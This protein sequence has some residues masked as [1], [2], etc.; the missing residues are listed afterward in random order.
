MIITFILHFPRICSTVFLA[1]IC[2]VVMHC[3]FYP[4]NSFHLSSLSA[5]LCLLFTGAL[6]VSANSSGF[7]HQRKVIH[8]SDVHCTGWERGIMECA[9]FTHTLDDGIMLMRNVKLEVVAVQCVS[10]CPPIQSSNSTNSTPNS[11]APECS[12]PDTRGKELVPLNYSKCVLFCAC[13]LN[14][15][16]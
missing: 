1:T 2:I 10:S 13:L 6:A 16:V 4:C 7:T 14:T 12:W 5:P 3:L 8:M 9:S 11:T 15:Y